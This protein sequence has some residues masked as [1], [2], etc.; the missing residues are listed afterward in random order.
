MRPDCP[1]AEA[2]QS[3]A[4]R[5]VQVARPAGAPPWALRGETDGRGLVELYDVYPGVRAAFGVFCAS[6][7]AFWHEQREDVLALDFCCAGRIGWDMRCG[8]AV[9]LGQ[10]DL[11]L[12]SMACCA[13][14]VLSLPLGFAS[15]VTLAVDLSVLAHTCPEILREAGFDAQALRARFCDGG[16]STLPAG[17]NL[18]EIFSPLL[19]A[20]KELRLPYLKLKS[21][22][23]LLYLSHLT[24]GAAK[25]TPVHAQQT[26]Q[27]RKVHAFLTAHLDQRYTIEDLSRQFLLNTATLK[28]VF[29]A[30]Y[31]Q[32]IAAYMKE[33]RVRQA[34]RLLRETDSSIADIAAAVGYESQGKFTNAFKDVAQVLPTEYR[35][36]HRALV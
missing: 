36:Q 1:W 6:R 8:A 17:P 9:Y 32:P 28:S 20:P 18:S 34:M 25:L 13:D 31:G 26:E 15:E 2:L 19:S 27:V 14:S 16:A 23:L 11:A 12:H 10:G 5:T 35:R 7:V 29:K 24:D 33:Y 30:V 21:Q 22:E 3:V 4:P